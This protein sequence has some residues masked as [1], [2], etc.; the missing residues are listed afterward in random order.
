MAHLRDDGKL[1]IM[2]SRKTEG[3]SCGLPAI[4]LGRRRWLPLHWAAALRNPE[5]IIFFMR[6]PLAAA[7]ARPAC[8]AVA[9]VLFESSVRASEKLGYK[10]KTFPGEYS[11]MQYTTLPG[12]DLAVSRIA[13]GCWALAGDMT[14]GPQDEA[15]GIAA[16]HA[17][18]DAGIN[19]FDTAEAYGNG[20]SEQMLG[21]ALAGARS[22]D[23]GLEIQSRPLRG[24]A[25][26]GLPPQPGAS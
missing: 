1:S 16:I 21:K 8:R 22:G 6:A 14:W 12:T 25:G 26:C 19:F 4:R 5:G 2:A 24:R 7:P 10:T 15:A 13:M 9:G 3:K 17:A 20:I 23:R 11:S 18:L